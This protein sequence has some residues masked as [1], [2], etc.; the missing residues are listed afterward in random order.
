MNP[1]KG[2]LFDVSRDPHVWWRPSPAT[3]SLNR[4]IFDDNWLPNDPYYLTNDGAILRRVTHLRRPGF[5]TGFLE[6]YVDVQLADT[7]VAPV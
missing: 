4:E 6:D 7:V 5:G 1:F 3:E 2:S